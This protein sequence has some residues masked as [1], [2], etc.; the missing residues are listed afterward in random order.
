MLI[1]G[2][3]STP[4]TAVGVIL[5]DGDGDPNGDGPYRKSQGLNPHEGTVA[6]VAG[7][8]GDGISRKGT[9]P[10]MRQI[11]L[12]HGSV[13]LDIE[14][15]TLTGTMIN[16]EQIRRDLFSIVKRGKVELARVENP[17]QPPPQDPATIT[18]FVVA[19][20]KDTVGAP[21]RGWLAPLGTHGTFIIHDLPESRRREAWVTASEKPFIAVYDGFQ[22]QLAQLEALV[23]VPDSPAP[24]GVVLA[25][26]NDANYYVYRLNA[27]TRSAELLQCRNGSEQ[28]ITSRKIDLP[29]DGDIQVELEPEGKVIEVQ[30]EVENDDFEYA[31]TL[32]Q[33]LPQGRFGVYVGPGGSAKYRSFEVER[34]VP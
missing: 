12:E 34:D 5:D 14:G 25:F 19:W 30:L 16:K 23:E 18:E 27:K 33:D 6:I 7:H 21:P 9:M 3:Y 20:D 1:D 13:I 8:G 15:D 2:A 29:L 4:T 31:I 22:G 32:D 26:E 24:A 28:V 10:I 17:W 11:I